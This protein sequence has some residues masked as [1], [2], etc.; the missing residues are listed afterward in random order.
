MQFKDFAPDLTLSGLIKNLECIKWP[1]S[2]A[3]Y[4][5]KTIISIK[6]YHKCKTVKDWK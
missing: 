5:L 6:V 2:M 1:T 3:C 4:K